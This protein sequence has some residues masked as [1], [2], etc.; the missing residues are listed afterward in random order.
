MLD[1]RYTT[2]PELKLVYFLYEVHVVNSAAARFDYGPVPVDLCWQ[3]GIIC[4]HFSFRLI[5]M[6]PSLGTRLHLNYTRNRKDKRIFK[7]EMTFRISTEH[8][9]EE[10]HS[11]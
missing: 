10:V 7:Q 3:S 11:N 8:L 9:T 4:E 2:V 5:I 1:S 6:S